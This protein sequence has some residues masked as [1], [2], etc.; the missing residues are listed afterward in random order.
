LVSR[1]ALAS[2]VPRQQTQETSF[3]IR[4]NVP[5][6]SCPLNPTLVLKPT[7]PEALVA[8]ASDTTSVSSPKANRHL[9]MPLGLGIGAGFIGGA[10]GG[11]PGRIVGISISATSLVVTLL[12]SSHPA[13]EPADVSLHIDGKL[14]DSRL[15][16][17]SGDQEVIVHGKRTRTISDKWSLI[18]EPAVSA[19]I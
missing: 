9:F 5:G 18:A 16:M 11:T 7:E 17:L 19:S 13:S 15:Q 3:R 12:R 10:I 2:H 14:A 4:I 6:T 8:D 1:V